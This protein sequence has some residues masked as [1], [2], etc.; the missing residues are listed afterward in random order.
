MSIAKTLTGVVCAATL[1]LAL[2]C[3]TDSMQNRHIDIRKIISVK[4]TFSPDFKVVTTGPTGIDPRLLAPQQLPP[5]ITVD[6]P[7][8]AKY[9]VRQAL[10]PGLKGNMTSLAAQV[11]NNRLLAVAVETAQPVAYEPVSDH[12]KHITF[13][14]RMLKGETYA[15][16]TPQIK[17]AKTLGTY[18]VL[19]TTV[20]DRT[21]STESYH[22]TAYL[23][24]HHL[25]LVA[26]NPIPVPNQAPAPVNVDRARRL[27]TDAIAAVRG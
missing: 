20:A 11:E 16:D 19:D 3:S 24:D 26:A 12:C 22:Y 18:N 8:C 27:L 10:R 2:G 4:S 5:G 15:I 1:L 13:T 14:G 23:G 7:D 25:V 21:R 9:A 6:P 17:G